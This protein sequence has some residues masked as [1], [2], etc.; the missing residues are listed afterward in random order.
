M[1]HDGNTVNYLPISPQKPLMVS[2]CT[3]IPQLLCTVLLMAYSSTTFQGPALGWLKLFCPQVQREGSAWEIS[4]TR[5]AH[6]FGDQL[7]D[8]IFALVYPGERLRLGLGLTPPLYSL[9][10]FWKNFL[11]KLTTQSEKYF[12]EILLAVIWRR[13]DW[14]RL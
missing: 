3:S 4:A 8:S 6:C 14:L 10:N 2:F 5:T 12:E 1:K 7:W 13:E 11:N 9:I